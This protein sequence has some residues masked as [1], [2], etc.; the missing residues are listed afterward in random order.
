MKKKPVA[1]V[2]QTPTKKPKIKSSGT[3]VMGEINVNL[4]QVNFTNSQ[5]HD[6]VGELSQ[7]ILSAYYRQYNNFENGDSNE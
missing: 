1:K 5:I 6:I 2:R 4:V 7:L 3:K